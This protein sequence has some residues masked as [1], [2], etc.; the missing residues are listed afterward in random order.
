MTALKSNLETMNI[1]VRNTRHPSVSFAQVSVGNIYHSAN[2]ILS[3]CVVSETV[4]EC[5]LMSTC[6]A[7][8]TLHI[9]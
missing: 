5:A 2:L 7:R 4:H 1:K 8:E 3:K 9:L 6:T